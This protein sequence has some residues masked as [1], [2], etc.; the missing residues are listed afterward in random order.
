MAE[1][2]TLPFFYA[3][4][5]RREG[6]TLRYPVSVTEYTLALKIFLP[7]FVTVVFT[8]KA[9]MRDTAMAY[10]KRSV[11]TLCG[12]RRGARAYYLM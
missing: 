5:E 3:L 7:V 10:I 4:K 2:D 8:D 11:N 9:E 6:A 1:A 12:I